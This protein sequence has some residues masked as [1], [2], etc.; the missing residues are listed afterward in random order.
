MRIKRC[1]ECYSELSD[2]GDMTEDG[3]ALDCRQ[4]QL[5]DEVKELR[6]QLSGLLARIHG[7]GGHYESKWGTAKA[8]TDAHVIVVDARTKMET[9]Q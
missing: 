3:P 9:D 8:V 1:D 6:S 2:C 7:D 5:S 4:C